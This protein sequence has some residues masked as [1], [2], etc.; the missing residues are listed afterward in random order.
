MSETAVTLSPADLDAAC[1]PLIDQV[2]A[3][4]LVSDGELTAL[5]PTTHEDV[6]AWLHC[7]GQLRVW[8]ANPKAT[9]PDTEAVADA[10]VTAA[11]REVAIPVP[12]LDGVS[13]Y[14]K[15]LE[16]MLQLR[17]LDAQLGRLTAALVRA[18]GDDAAMIEI[19]GGVQLATATSYVMQLLAWAW[20]SPGHGLPFA[21]HEAMPVVPAHVQ[22]WTPAD[23]LAITQAAHEF[24]AS[25]VAVQELV[26]P[27]PVSDGGRR[28]SWAAF[29][30]AVG[31]STHIDPREL[32][33]SHSLAKVLSMAYLANDRLRPRDQGDR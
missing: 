30:E 21:A 28:R 26:D 8:L 10:L 9:G 12:G 11:I 2:R 4:R 27:V 29:F 15:S 1:T 24:T 31:A 16:G 19:D 20:T 25:L 13:V 7:Y 6:W 3:R 18:I 5:V 23:L 17:V 32:A 22:A 14:P 33:V